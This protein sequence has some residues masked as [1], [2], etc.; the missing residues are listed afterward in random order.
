MQ[1]RRMSGQTILLWVSVMIVL[2]SMQS[3]DD[4]PPVKESP[5]DLFWSLET[6]LEHPLD[7]HALELLP[8]AL[9]NL[10]FKK[11]CCILSS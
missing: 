11:D 5:V 1:R 2:W 7:V 6:A 3:C 4:R 8:R 10:H 9:Y